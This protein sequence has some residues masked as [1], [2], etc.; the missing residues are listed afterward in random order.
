MKPIFTKDTNKRLNKL[1]RIFFENIKISCEVG[2]SIFEFI[3]V[4]VVWIFILRGFISLFALW[5]VE[6]LNSPTLDIVMLTKFFWTMYG[7]WF[8]L[9]IIIRMIKIKTYSED[10]K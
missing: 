4:Q 9:N 5:I 2:A 3:L 8:F 7:A 1:K 6:L 10:K